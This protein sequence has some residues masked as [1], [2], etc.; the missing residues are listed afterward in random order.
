LTSAR[1]GSSRAITQLILNLVEGTPIL[2]I[3]GGRQ[4][5]CFT[6]VTDG[7]E[8][9]YRIIEN[10]NGVCDGRIINI[11]DPDNEVSIRGL[12]EL[13]LAKFEQHPLRPK[14]PP[15]AGF[16]VVESSSY[17]G[18]GYQDVQYRKPSIRNARKLLG[19]S[20]TVD[21]ENSVE[22]TL[23]F[24]LRT[25]IEHG[26]FLLFPESKP[27]S[28]HKIVEMLPGGDKGSLESKVHENRLED[29]R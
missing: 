1:I 14:F 27:A 29:R 10:K 20:P 28:P 21:L 4:K 5:R 11:G 18:K 7:V 19:W 3:D 26:E 16:R 23:D 12:A 15:F 25:G 22:R 9:L 6:D 2:L 24:F 17:Y 8:C 13:L